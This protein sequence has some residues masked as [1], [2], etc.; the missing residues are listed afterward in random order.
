MFSGLNAIAQ[1]VQPSEP[2][3]DLNQ[4]LFNAPDDGFESEGRPPSRTSAGSR[5]SCLDLLIALV[6]GRDT[7]RV[8]NND[9]GGYSASL[10][11]LTVSAQPTL[12]FY[13]PESVRGGSAELVL[14]DTNQQA[15]F[16]QPV[17]IGDAQGIIRVALNQPLEIERPYHWVFSVE[18]R[19]NTAE[20]LFVEG[21][22]QRVAPNTTLAAALTSAPSKPEQMALYAEHGIWHDALTLLLDLRRAAPTDTVLANQWT[23]FI[24][25]V[26][27]GAIADA[28]VSACCGD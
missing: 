11:A 9:C 15:T 23:S 24:E 7:V 3:A 8:D 16:V 25:S 26:G 14:L 20:P 28:P 10:M 27:L 18:G 21:F 4:L 1:V 5:N 19:N 6:P 2:P 22:I 17:T 12:W 13:L